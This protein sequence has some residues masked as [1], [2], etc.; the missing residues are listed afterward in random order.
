MYIVSWDRIL[1]PNPYKSLK[2]LRKSLIHNHLYS[3]PWDLYFFKLTQPLTV[4]TVQLLY[5]EKDKGGKPDRNH[6]QFPLEFHTETSSMSTLK[7]MP[8]NL[9]E[10][11]RSGIRLLHIEHV[12]IDWFQQTENLSQGRPMVVKILFM[13]ACHVLASHI[14][15]TIGWNVVVLWY[16]IGQ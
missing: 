15:K 1:G 4:S 10:I 16:V 13:E 3:F 8:W 6:I 9:N 7:I 2:S 5:T 12:R 14:C 11:V